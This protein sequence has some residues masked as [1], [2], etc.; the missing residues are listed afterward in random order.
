M[1]PDTVNGLPLHPLTVHATVVLVPLLALL[2]VLFVIP[3]IREWARWPL[4]LVAV[5][6]AASTYVSI[7]DR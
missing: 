4:G 5:A 7:A 3:R 2:G 6:A 1:L